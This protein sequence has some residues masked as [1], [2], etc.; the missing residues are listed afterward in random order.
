M[1]IPIRGITIEIY[2]YVST[3]NADTDWGSSVDGYYSISFA[4]NLNTQ[5][6]IVGVWDTT[7]GQQKAYPDLVESVN[8]NMVKISVS[9]TPDGR[10][11]GKI[12]IR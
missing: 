1:R 11:A 2:D 4:H 8:K 9:E 7:A 6:I 12:V 5:D 10:F 3:F